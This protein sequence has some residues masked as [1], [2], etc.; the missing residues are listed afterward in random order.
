ME[1][2]P[3]LFVH[4]VLEVAEG[5]ADL[6]HALALSVAAQRA[7]LFLRYTD[8]HNI[9]PLKHQQSSAHT[10]LFAVDGTVA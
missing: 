3:G 8:A 10:S 6:R 2:H 1:T 7:R 9:S 4:L 5:P